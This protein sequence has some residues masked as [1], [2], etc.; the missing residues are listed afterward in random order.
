MVVDEPD[1]IVIIDFEVVQPD[2]N[3]VPAWE[4]NNGSICI[5]ITGGTNPFPIGT[6]WSE[7]TVVDNGV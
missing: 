2:C 4:F 1:P 5:T 7:T 3:T 6:G